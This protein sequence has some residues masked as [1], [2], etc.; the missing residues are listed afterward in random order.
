MLL[1]PEQRERFQGYREQGRREQEALIS[2]LT[3][4]YSLDA[5]SK[6]FK[7]A[8]SYAWEQGHSAGYREVEN[9]FHDIMSVVKAFHGEQKP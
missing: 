5:R 2:K 7:A 9:Y 3:T 1:T 4:T 6:G 8:W